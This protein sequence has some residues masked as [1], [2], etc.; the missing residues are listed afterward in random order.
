MRAAGKD[1]A[2][3]DITRN[4]ASL[5]RTLLLASALTSVFI[6]A[7][8]ARAGDNPTATPTSGSTATATP[9]ASATGTYP[10]SSSSKPAQTS[11]RAENIQ[12]KIQ[13]R[14]LRERNSPSAVT[15]LGQSQISQV[16]IGASPASL[17]RQAP[18]V[19]V[20]QQGIGNSE[21]VISIR[22]IRGLE[23]AQTLDGVPTQDLLNGGGGGLLVGVLGGKFDISQISAVSIYPGVAYPNI[24]TFG[25]IGGTIAYSTDRP[26][27]DREIDVIGSVG[28]YGT[29]QEGIKLNTGR[30]DGLFGTGYDAPKALLQYTNLQTNGYIDYTNAKYNNFEGAFDKP[31]DDGLSKFQ[32]TVLYNTANGLIEPDPVPVPYLQQNGMFSNYDPSTT[33]DRQQNQFLTLIL[34]NDTYVNDFVSFGVSLFYEYENSLDTG[35][36]NPTAVPPTGETGSATV[37]GTNPFAYFVPDAYGT[38]NLYLPGGFFAQPPTF[39]YNG[40]T[41]YD[42]TAA[43][44]ASVRAQYASFGYTPCGYN[45]YAQTTTT[46]TYGIQPHITI[47]PNT[48]YGI[49]NTIEIGGIIG[50]ETGQNNPIYL[51]GTPTVPQTAAN[52][53][54][55]TLYGGEYRDIYQAFAQDKIDFLHNTLHVT[56]GLTLETSSSGFNAA[57]ELDTAVP[58]AVTTSAAV[59]NNPSCLSYNGPGVGPGS[60]AVTCQYGT[61]SASKWDREL[62]PFANVTYDLDHVLPAIKGTSLYASYGES[63]LFAPVAD[64]TPN[65]AGGVPTASIVHLYEGGVK[66]NTSN[67]VLSTDYF[68][69]K[70]D[71]D[72]GFFTIQSGPQAGETLYENLGER[73]FKG[74]EASVIWQLSPHWQLFGNMSHTLAKYLVTNFADTTVQEEQYGLAIRGQPISGVPPWIATFGAQYDRRNLFIQHDGFHARFEGQFTG[75]QPITYDLQG[76]NNNV[77]TLPGG[78]G[79]FGSYLY[80]N[81]TQ[82]ATVTDPNTNAPSYVVF[83]LDMD[84]TVPVKQLNVPVLKS[85]DFDLNFTNLFNN[86][87]FQYY[88]REIASSTPT[89]ITAPAP[90]NLIGLP[91][92][93]YPGQ[94]FL[95]GIPGEPFAVTLTATAKF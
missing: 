16:G 44:A 76:A 68:Y 87:Y 49:R 66:Y 36:I 72:F 34:H 65:A 55:G 20:Y 86:H 12:V 75:P 91:T 18:S 85:L 56:P 17:L 10:S 83:N 13:R 67:L 23:T 37:G 53:Q 22:G 42:N 69:Q 48:V 78:I 31:F 43:C 88:Y 27:N 80:Y 81:L 32:A 33:F 64:F 79:S 7:S 21:P 93:N 58:G 84:Y 57:E 74:V 77:G 5:R 59:L 45:A 62:L 30:M 1:W 28:S 35:Y 54:P 89:T 61:Y 8:A 51:G 90:A 15:E 50:R 52:I 95:S 6:A 94:N 47:T 46:Q 29:Y 71:R 19:N 92:T 11:A 40:N 70:V 9:N 38:E 41:Q 39:P 82:G 60:G 26:T 14:L 3:V 73:E 25:T 4:E 63:S 24:N 2:Q